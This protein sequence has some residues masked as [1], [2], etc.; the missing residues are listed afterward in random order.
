MNK[1]F[2]TKRIF[3][4][5]AMLLILVFIIGTVVWHF[6][7]SALSQAKFTTIKKIQIV[8]NTH[9]SNSFLQSVATPFL[10]ENIYEVDLADLQLRY[11]SISRVKSVTAKTV[12]PNKLKI[13][14]TERK[15]LFYVKDST[16]EYY[17]IDEEMMVLD[18]ADWY[19]T[20][21]LPLINYAL[22]KESIVVGKKIENKYVKDIYAIYDLMKTTHKDIL[23]EVSEFYYKNS[24]IHFIDS[25]SGCRVIISPE[26]IT[27]QISRFLFIRNNQG[28]DKNSTVDLRFDT[29]VIIS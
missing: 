17:P 29:Q 27:S 19:T 16:G 4:R 11:S 25:V 8:G 24:D 18:K 13:T 20:E 26:N 21:D 7:F 1:R 12:F 2:F 3:V 14:I 28:I 5:A 22:P 23:S 6:T 9:L 10:N 15:G